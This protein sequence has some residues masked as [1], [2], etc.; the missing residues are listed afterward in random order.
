MIWPVGQR[1]NKGSSFP[2]WQIQSLWLLC[3]L[4]LNAKAATFGLDIQRMKMSK[5]V[6][7]FYERPLETLQTTILVLMSEFSKTFSTPASMSWQTERLQSNAPKVSR[8][9]QDT[10][11]FIVAWLRKRKK[12]TTTMLSCLECQKYQTIPEGWFK[13]WPF[14]AWR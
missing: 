5:K 7:Q 11:L 8:S 12:G 14:T 3:W 1:V 9:V 4:D 10:A 6:C 2:Q 13:R